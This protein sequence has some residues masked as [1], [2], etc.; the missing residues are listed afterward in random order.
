MA[1]VLG[2]N[3]CKSIPESVIIINI[4]KHKSYSTAATF[5]LVLTQPYFTISNKDFVYDFEYFSFCTHKMSMYMRGSL[6]IV[7][8]NQV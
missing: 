2:Q 7:Y 8:V 3:V 6:N 5:L 4:S 1:R